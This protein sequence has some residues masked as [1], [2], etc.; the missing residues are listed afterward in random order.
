MAG[1]T[2]P[3]LGETLVLLGTACI[4]VPLFKKFGL[5]SVLGYL[6]AG[7]AIGPIASLVTDGENLGSVAELGIVLLLFLIGLELKPSLLWTMRRDIFGLGAAQVVFTAA[8]LGVPA[9]WLGFS[10]GQSVVIALALVLSSTAIAMQTLEDR[11]DRSRDYG[12]TSFSVLLFQDLAIVPL[13]ALTSFL[14]PVDS[15]GPSGLE[16]LA[17]TVGAV[18]ALILIGRFALNPLFQLLARAQAR[19]IMTAASLFVVLGA[20]WLMA[21]VGLSMALGAFIAG[22]MLAESAYRHQLEADLEP[23]RGLLMGLF[24]LSV[25][26]TVNL[27]IV[28]QYWYIIFIAAPV[29]MVL[30]AVTLYALCR[31]L[32]CSHN[33]SVKTSLLLSQSGEFAFVVFSLGAGLLYWRRR[34]LHCSLRQ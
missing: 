32:R 13:L 27:T 31:L 21:Q 6:A 20:A 23:F 9:Y 1:S 17:I 34:T 11:G 4:A 3:Y 29:I 7:L 24:F 33:D 14:A 30:K 25:G 19:E 5:G 26:L 8:V 28:L 12:R 22:V 15:Q 10:V 16:G 18:A 2:V